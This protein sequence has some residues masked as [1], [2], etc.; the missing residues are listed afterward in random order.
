MKRKTTTPIKTMITFRQTLGDQH[1]T[2]AVIEYFCKKFHYCLLQDKIDSNDY[3]LI[4][5]G[6]ISLSIVSIGLLMYN[7]RQFSID[8][9]TDETITETMLKYCNIVKQK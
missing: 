5:Y 9:T 2:D 8:L 4:I 6:N 1:K 3:T 7:L